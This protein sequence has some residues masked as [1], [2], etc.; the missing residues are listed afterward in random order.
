MCVI[1]INKKLK[2]I[3]NLMIYVCVIKS[4]KKQKLWIIM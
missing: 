3:F 1:G 4:N 2:I